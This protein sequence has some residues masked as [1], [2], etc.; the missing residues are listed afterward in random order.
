MKSLFSIVS[1]AL[2]TSAL[3]VN[4]GSIVNAIRPWEYA[5]GYEATACQN[6]GNDPH[7]IHLVP[8][9]HCDVGWIFPMKTYFDD[10]DNM[11]DTWYTN[12]ISSV[13]EILTNVVDGLLMDKTRKFSWVEIVYFKDWWN[14]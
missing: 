1:L 6:I 8:H 11:P 4:P 13:K 7:T 2:S 3:K 14:E 12:H 10:I 9:S 5:Q